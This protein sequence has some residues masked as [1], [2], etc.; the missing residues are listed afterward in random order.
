M[1]RLYPARPLG[2]YGRGVKASKNHG[3]HSLGVCGEVQTDNAASAGYLLA[4]PDIPQHMVDQF[5]VSRGHLGDCLI[6][7]L[8]AGLDARGE[9]GDLHSA[10]M[11]IVS[12]LPWPIA[13]LRCDRDEN[14]PITAL[15]ASWEVDRPQID[16]YIQRACN[17]PAF[18]PVIRCAGRRVE[19]RQWTA[20]DGIIDTPLHR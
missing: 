18:S 1:G 8:Q 11:Q 20:T 2:F 15:R 13:D 17:S 7:T 16:D 10:G 14:C 9:A 19:P 6:S 12:D 5:H 4:N 3:S